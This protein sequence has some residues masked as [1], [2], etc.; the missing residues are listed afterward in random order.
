MALVVGAGEQLQS[1]A[2][3]VLADPSPLPAG[4][5]EALDRCTD[6]FIGL[7][8]HLFL[9]RS[10]AGKV[11]SPHGLLVIRLIG[12]YIHRIAVLIWLFSAAKLEREDDRL[13]AHTIAVEL[14]E[15]GATVPYNSLEF[16]ETRVPALARP[17]LMAQFERLGDVEIGARLRS[18]AKGGL[19]DT[20][21]HQT[22]LRAWQNAF[23]RHGDAVATQLLDHLMVSA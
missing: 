13:L 18:A 2:L 12:E 1:A 4:V 10:E 22:F 3:C 15:R 6:R 9:A 7:L 11:S 8:P 21:A 5:V 17:W 23:D 19:L 20:R 14:T 16:V